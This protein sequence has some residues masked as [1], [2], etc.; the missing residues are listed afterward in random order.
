MQWRT[1]PRGSVVTRDMWGSPGDCCKPCTAGVAGTTFIFR[2]W[3]LS[4]GRTHDA[5][6][7]LHAHNWLPR[8]EFLALHPRRQGMAC[9]RALRLCPQAPVIVGVGRCPRSA[10]VERRRLHCR[11]V[12]SARAAASWHPHKTSSAAVG[13]AGLAMVRPPIPAVSPEAYYL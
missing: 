11:E 1:A 5:T 13:A 2:P 10:G 7:A 9:F 12:S 8:A 3:R 4:S 6:F